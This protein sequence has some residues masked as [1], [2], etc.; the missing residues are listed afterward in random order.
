MPV[1][2]GP[3]PPS[4]RAVLA[5]FGAGAAAAGLSA[6]APPGDGASRS[7]TL[8]FAWW[9]NDDR[10]ERTQRAVR[11]FEEENPGITVSTS[12]GEFGSYLQKIATQAAGGGI[13]DVAQLDYRQISQFALGG[14]LLP[15]DEAIASE[16]VHTDRMDADFVGTGA[17]DDTQYA[18]PMGRGITGYAYDSELFERAGIGVPGPDWTWEEFADAARR[19]TALGTT[20]PAG[21]TVTGANDGA[22]NQDVYE[23]WLHSKGKRLYADQGRLGFTAD[24]LAEFWT[25]FNDLRI[26]GVVPRA[27]DTAQ[28]SSLDTSPMVRGLSAADF[29]W[30]APFP[31]YIGM[32]GDHIR[33]APVPTFDGRAG[34]YFKPSMLVGIGAGTRHPEEAARLVDFLLN[35]PRAGDIMA[36]SRSTPPN[37]DIAE[38]VSETLEGPALEIYRYA[39]A[40]ESYG[41]TSPPIPPPPVDL[42]AQ[43]AFSRLYQRV[44]FELATPEEAAQEL[45]AEVNRGLH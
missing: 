7:I 28:A 45:V 40:M 25:F 12:N 5:A 23:T 11:L 14:A 16:T 19:V 26:E 44:I 18:I 36:F 2:R 29:T 33:Y 35:D 37:R 27:T 6:C 10:A 39:E 38:R 42:S 22:A 8:T 31:D 15:L 43:T 41:L 21:R 4:R 32:L 17:V 1:P 30:D 20:G 13:P 3:R 24:D 9:G 34:T